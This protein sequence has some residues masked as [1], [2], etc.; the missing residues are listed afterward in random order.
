M[1]GYKC[2]ICNILLT[3]YIGTTANFVLRNNCKF[4]FKYKRAKYNLGK[5]RN[6]KTYLIS[7]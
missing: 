4:R 2:I 7:E 1:I 6:Y 5:I 3:P